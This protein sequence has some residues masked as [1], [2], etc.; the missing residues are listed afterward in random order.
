MI[1]RSTAKDPKKRYP[2]MASMLADLEG[3]LEVEVAGA[4]RTARRP[5][6]STRFRAAAG[7]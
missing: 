7:S 2:D 4:G 1:E 6:C 3:A 5:T